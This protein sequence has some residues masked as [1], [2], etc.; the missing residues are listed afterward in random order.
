MS[1]MS[2]VNNS[3]KDYVKYSKKESEVLAKTPDAFSLFLNS[4]LEFAAKQ[5]QILIGLLIIAL[6]AGVA[7][8]FYDS[9]NNRKEMALQ[10]K[11]AAAEKEQIE[12][13]RQFE[14]S[15]RQNLLPK[16]AKSSANLKA[17]SGDLEK[18]YGTV[19]KQYS[20]VVS[21][22]PQSR[23]ARMAA[24]KASDLLLRYKQGEEALKIISQVSENLKNDLTSQLAFFQ[25]AN[26]QAQNGHC[27]EA[28]KT[29]EKITSTKSAAFLHKE[30]K[31][32]MGLCYETMNDKSKA[33][34]LFT[35]AA[36]SD[37]KSE[38]GPAKDA[39]KYLRLL[40]ITQGEG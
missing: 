15:E 4:A 13:E 18:D 27:S 22:A 37:E 20:E 9:V 12:K 23:A 31:L 2:D 8:G 39:E 36:K 17:A 34:Q 40:R 21:Q 38:F 35:E 29:W 6:L 3:K 14:E 25:K 26:V 1:Q 7:Y 30:A 32:R 24:I 33:E 11:Y 16:E 5:S 19:V 28:V 10:E